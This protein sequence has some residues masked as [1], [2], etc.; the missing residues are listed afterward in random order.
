[1]AKRRREVR[2]TVV[3]LLIAAIASVAVAW[4]AGEPVQG[5]PVQAQMTGHEVAVRS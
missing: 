5:K 1:V 2:N 3:K 4:A